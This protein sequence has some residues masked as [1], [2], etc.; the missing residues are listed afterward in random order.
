MTRPRVF[1]IKTD[2][3][4]LTQ[5][6]IATSFELQH[7]TLRTAWKLETPRFH[8]F[9]SGF[10]VVLMEASCFDTWKSVFSSLN[11]CHVTAFIVILASAL[12]KCKPHCQKMPTLSW[13]YNPKGRKTI[14]QL[15][16]FWW[17]SEV[18]WKTVTVTQSLYGHHELSLITPYFSFNHNQNDLQRGSTLHQVKSVVKHSHRNN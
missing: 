10:N 12:F 6:S 3:S 18:L 7:S 16:L 1:Q 9:Q 15:H 13:S 4:L 17:C 8:Q 2:N 14:Q 5:P 11:S